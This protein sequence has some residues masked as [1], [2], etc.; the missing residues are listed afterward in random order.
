[1]YDA[2]IAGMCTYHYNIDLPSSLVASPSPLEFILDIVLT[3]D[4][5]INQFTTRKTGTTVA[6]YQLVSLPAG[7]T[8]AACAAPA[9][10]LGCRTYTLARNTLKTF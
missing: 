8:Q 2:A 1:M 7:V 6:S 3:G 5:V 10:S 4:V 9:N